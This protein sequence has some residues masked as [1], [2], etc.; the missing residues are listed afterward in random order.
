MEIEKSPLSICTKPQAEKERG[1]KNKDGKTGY[2]GIQTNPTFHGPTVC[3]AIKGAGLW[4]VQDVP[5]FCC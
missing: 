2:R 4:T 1:G 5:S 3:E